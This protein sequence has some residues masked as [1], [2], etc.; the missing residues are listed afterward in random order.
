MKK[1]QFRCKVEVENTRG[2]D[3]GQVEEDNTNDGDHH[4]GASE[5]GG[6]GRTFCIRSRMAA[7]EH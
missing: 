3:G 4:G 2:R 5:A 7:R 1:K 6:Q